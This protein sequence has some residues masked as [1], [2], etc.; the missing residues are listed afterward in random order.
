MHCASC[1]AACE[2]ILRKMQGV[3]EASVNLVNEQAH[4]VY[5]PHVVKQS[6]LFAAIAKGGYQASLE[7][8]EEQPQKRKTTMP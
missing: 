5:D 1:S 8:H 6:E 3:K 7:K 2:R 4:V